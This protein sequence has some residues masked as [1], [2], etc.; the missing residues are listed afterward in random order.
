MRNRVILFINLLCASL[1][2]FTVAYASGP[3]EG[4]RRVRLENEPAGPYLIRVVTSPTPPTVEN[5]NIEVKVL[6]QETGGELLDA[7]VLVMAQPEG[8]SAASISEIATHEF[9]PLPTEYAAHLAIPEAGLWLV[10]VQ[11]QTDLGFGEVSFYQQI[12]NPPRLGAL[13]SIG[14]PVGGLLILGMVFFWLQKMSA[15]EKTRSV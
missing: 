4:G 2:G 5:F 11:V 14:A 8:F 9:A 6:R 12:S 7:E 10:T 13:I 15:S 1:L 3:G